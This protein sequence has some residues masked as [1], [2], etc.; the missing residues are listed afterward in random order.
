[1]KK[2]TILPLYNHNKENIGKNDTLTPMLYPRKNTILIYSIHYENKS[3][4]GLVT[5]A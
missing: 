1:M 3:S 4:T 2:I 5:Y